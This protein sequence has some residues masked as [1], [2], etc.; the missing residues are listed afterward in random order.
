VVPE[1]TEAEMKVQISAIVEAKRMSHERMEEMKAANMKDEEL[2]ALSAQVREG[3]PQNKNEV[4]EI[5]RP[6]WN[7]RHEITIADGMVMKT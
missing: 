1:I 5:I 4:P 6:Y 3:W 2:R 7:S